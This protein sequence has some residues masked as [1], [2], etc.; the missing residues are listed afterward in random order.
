M[1][2]DPL[3][4]FVVLDD[5]NP[6]NIIAAVQGTYLYRNGDIFFATNGVE[7]E[8][9]RFEVSKRALAY[10]YSNEPWWTNIEE[11]RITYAHEKEI[12]Y[13]DSGDGSTGWKFIS[14]DQSY[15]T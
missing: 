7:S 12:W 10:R 13:K 1:R 8:L 4:R 5:S 6:E 3:T 14:F 11:F 15:T 2:I 9:K